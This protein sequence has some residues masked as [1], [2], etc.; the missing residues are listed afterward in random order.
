MGIILCQVHGKQNF[1]KV[2]THIWKEFANNNFPPMRKLPGYGVRVC[3][4][5][6]EENY[7]E[8][9]PKITF[10]Q[11]L[12]LPEEAYLKLSETLYPKYP[13]LSGSIKCVECIRYIELISARKNKKEPSFEPFENT[14]MYRDTE[15]IEELK[16]VLTSNFKFPK[17]RKSPLCFKPT[18]A[19]FIQS[20]GFSYPFSI[21]FYYITEKRHQEEILKLIDNF[22]EEIPQKQRHISFYESEN[23]ITEKVKIGIRTYKGEEKLLLENIVK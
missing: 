2:C 11:L 15:K 22:F 9:L 16:K 3:D 4:K 20:G 7:V 10:E 19:F 6:Y 12:N 13:N 18:D 14:L 21:K 8:E 1:S 5:C 23:W 17:F